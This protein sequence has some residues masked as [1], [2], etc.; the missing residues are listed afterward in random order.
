MGHPSVY[1]TG[2]TLYDPQRAWSGYTVFQATERGAIL[3]DMN[4]NVVREWP[5]LHGF[6]NKILPGGRSWATAANAIPATGC[7][8]CST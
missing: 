1:P 4:G 8:I 2:A 3:V 7:R 5:E 6:P